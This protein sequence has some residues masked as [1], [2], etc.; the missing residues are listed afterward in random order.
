[1]PV[2]CGLIQETASKSTSGLKK[3]CQSLED[4][5]KAATLNACKT[6]AK[7]KKG[8]GTKSPKCNLRKKGK[9]AAPPNLLPKKNSVSTNTP[10][11]GGNNKTT[12][13]TTT[14]IGQ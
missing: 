4:K 2:L 1:M 6:A 11:Q 10:A 7:N 12:V 3:H 9:P 13:T 5:L 8:D 14:R